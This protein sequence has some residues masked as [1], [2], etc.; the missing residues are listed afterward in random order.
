MA[1]IFLGGYGLYSYGPAMAEM[2]PSSY[3]LHIYGP[4]MAE[5]FPSSYGLHIY[6]PAMAVHAAKGNIGHNYVG[7]NYITPYLHTGH[8]QNSQLV[9]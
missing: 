2:F 1:E 8:K 4:A 7:H 6:G 5:M 3:G 9:C